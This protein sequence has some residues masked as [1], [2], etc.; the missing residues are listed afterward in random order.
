[1]S[2]TPIELAEE[3]SKKTAAQDDRTELGSYR[4]GLF[5]G[6]LSGYQSAQ[7]AQWIS[8][9]DKLPEVNTWC[10]WLY[11]TGPEVNQYEGKLPDGTLLFHRSWYDSDDEVTHWMMLPA[12]P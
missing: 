11:P 12:E 8:V 7:Q 9:K 6:F 5:E 1:M 10:L 2:K 4:Q 3:F